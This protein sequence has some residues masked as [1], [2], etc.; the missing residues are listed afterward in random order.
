MT[1]II[2]ILSIDYDEGYPESY[3]GVEIRQRGKELVY[4]SSGVPQDDLENAVA[5]AK[6]KYWLYCSSMLDHFMM[7]GGE[8]DPDLSD[9]LTMVGKISLKGSLK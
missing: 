5:W 4:F 7:E 1:D 6:D 3:R 2:A 8:L 9:F